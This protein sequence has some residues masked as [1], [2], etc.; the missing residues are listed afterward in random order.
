MALIKSKL[1]KV[2][3]MSDGGQV[4]GVE[5]TYA[6]RFQRALRYGIEGLHGDA[7]ENYWE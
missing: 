7:P 5:E 3:K 6:E 4:P 1:S 2:K